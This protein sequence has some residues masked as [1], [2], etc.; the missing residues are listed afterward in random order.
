MISG[1]APVEC[2]VARSLEVFRFRSGFKVNCWSARAVGVTGALELA[3]ID[4]NLA[5]Q[6]V[7][8]EA[9]I[10]VSYA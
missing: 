7:S 1:A 8:P 2:C 6:Y 4:R 3:H 5:N 9:G 10:G